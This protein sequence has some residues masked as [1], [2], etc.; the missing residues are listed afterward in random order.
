MHIIVCVKQVPDAKDVRMDLRI[1]TL[2]REGVESR[3][4]RCTHYRF[5]YLCSIVQK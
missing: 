5:L 1:N 4:R 2:S 3:I